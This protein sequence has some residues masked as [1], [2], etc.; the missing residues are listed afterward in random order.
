MKKKLIIYGIGKFTDYISYLFS[1]DSDFEVAAYC[2]E[3]NYLSKLKIGTL[4]LPMVSLEEVSEKFPPD[5]YYFFI[6][7]GNDQLRERIFN[8]C[9]NKKYRLASFISSKSVLYPEISVGENVFISE[10]TAIQPFVKIAN[11]SFLIGARVGHHSEI[12]KNTLLSLSSIGANCVI[13]DNSFLGINSA[14]KPNT[15]IGKKNIIGMGC[16]ITKDTL[17]FEVYSSS[18][19]KKRNLSYNDISDKYL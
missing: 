1:N 14:V 4:D 6:A 17:D 10:D 19:T 3:A 5:E 13:G 9:K 8:E 11:N 2:L 16:I 12:G 7:I 15:V 18:T